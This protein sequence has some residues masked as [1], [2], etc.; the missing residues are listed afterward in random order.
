MIRRILTAIILVIST[1]AAFAEPGTL[2]WRISRPGSDH[3]SY[4][5][6]THHVAPGAM[7]DSISGLRSAIA[8]ADAVYGEISAEKLLS[9][10]AQQLMLLAAQAPADSTL[11]TLLTPAQLVRIDSVMGMPGASAMLATMKPAM[12]ETQL[13]L[14]L[15]RRA[16]PDFDPMHSFDIEVMGIASESGIPVRDLE[17]VESQIDI[18]LGNPVSEQAESLRE[19]LD[20]LDTASASMAELAEAYRATDLDR[21]YSAMTATRT[22]AEERRWEQLVAAR[23]RA[24]VDKL[25]PVLDSES[26]LIAVGA[27]HLPGPDGLIKLLRRAGFTVTPLT[28]SA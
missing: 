23:N 2:L 7:I 17:T 3:T 4:L 5:L 8:S 14:V 15:T 24:W 20:N 28:P 27:G 16:C 10:R 1:Y 19:L 6:G 25:L 9:P 13:A 18:L 21:L 26:V 22:D 12:T 11:A